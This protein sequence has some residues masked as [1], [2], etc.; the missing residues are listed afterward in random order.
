LLIVHKENPTRCNNVSE[1][2]LF[3][4]YIKLNMF[5]AIHAHH[6]KP[7]TALAASGF[8]YVQRPSTYE[9]PEAASAVL[10]S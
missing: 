1:F 4:I 7:K 9:K 10:G 3:H 8:S 2:L 5:W 6:Q